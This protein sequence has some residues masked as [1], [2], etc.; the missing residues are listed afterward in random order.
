M[1]KNFTFDPDRVNIWVNDVNTCL[2]GEEPSLYRTCMLFNEQLQKLVQPDVWTGSAAA[3]NYQAFVETHN[4]MVDFINLFSSVF[5]EKMSYITYEL[6]DMENDKYFYDYSI[7]NMFGVLN[8]NN[9]KK[10]SEQNIN[11]SIIRYDYN[12]I[13]A[14]KNALNIIFD[15]LTEVRKTLEGKL[16]VLNDNTG[17][18]D[19]SAALNAKE[20]L[21]NLLKTN[22]DKIFEH[23]DTCINNIE[24]ALENAKSVD[25]M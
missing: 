8:Y 2:N 5:K 17:L 25:N 3:R 9:L 13:S 1:T 19:G 11:K 20:D 23:L 22:M 16:E 18:W 6:M 12:T 4:I 7:L 21:S 24:L 10:L 14:I 15:D